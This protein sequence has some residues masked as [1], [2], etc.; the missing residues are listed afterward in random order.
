MD[1]LLT[2]SRVRGQVR[3]ANLALAPAASA[4][5]QNILP[6]FPTTDGSDAWMC[7]A[8]VAFPTTFGAPRGASGYPL[9]L[10][11]FPHALTSWLWLPENSFLSVLHSHLWPLLSPPRLGT[12]WTSI[13]PGRVRNHSQIAAV[14]QKSEKKVNQVTRG[15]QG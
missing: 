8:K 10:S 4:V 2:R 3:W 14:K 15:K 13:A 6:P 5:G 7:P 1:F 12:Y 11:V 9:C